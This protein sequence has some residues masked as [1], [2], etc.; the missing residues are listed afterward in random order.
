MWTSPDEPLVGV[1]ECR[2]PADHV[3]VVR[4]DAQAVCDL[5]GLHPQ[6]PAEA[7]VLGNGSGFP[8]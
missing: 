6:V 3:P 1:G 5:L 8:A 4:R 2:D 7:V